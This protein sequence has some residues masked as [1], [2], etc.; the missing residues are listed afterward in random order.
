LCQ[1]DGRVGS[2]GCPNGFSD[3]S[4]SERQIHPDSAT[5]PEYFDFHSPRFLVC[6]LFSSAVG[7][8]AISSGA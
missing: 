5:E 2:N 3:S 4:P 6:A 8:R 7:V 1:E